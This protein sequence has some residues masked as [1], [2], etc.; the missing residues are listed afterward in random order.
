MR[1]DSRS[2][3]ANGPS[4]LDCV[5]SG[6]SVCK[7]FSLLHLP[8]PCG[9]SINGVPVDPGG[10]YAPFKM[11][12]ARGSLGLCMSPAARLLLYIHN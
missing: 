2:S 11:L 10:K 7:R 8:M 1:P 3:K 9:A 4:T 5:E 12:G 6:V